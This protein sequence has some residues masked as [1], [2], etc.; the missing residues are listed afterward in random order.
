MFMPNNVTLLSI[1]TNGLKSHSHKLMTFSALINT[2]NPNIFLAQ[3]TNLVDV[4]SPTFNILKSKYKL[5]HSE[6]PHVGS[7]LLLGL[8]GCAKLSSMT[9]LHPG[10][11]QRAHIQ[12]GSFQL[13][14]Y[15]LHFPPNDCE[16]LKNIQSKIIS[17]I[18]K[19]PN[20]PI[21]LG[22]DFNFVEDPKLDSTNPHRI[23]TSA[24]KHFV[25]A[26]EH[27]HFT[28]TFRYLHPQV[29]AF[30]FQRGSSAQSRIDKFY[31]ARLPND[32]IVES[33][34]LYYPLSDHQPIFLSLSSNTQPNTN[35][36]ETYWKLNNELLSQQPFVNEVKTFW[37]CWQAQKPFFSTRG[38]WWD[39]GKEK[40][41]KIAIKHG[42]QLKTNKIT[43][44]QN[45]Q[46]I[47]DK[48]ISSVSPDPNTI[49]GIQQAF[50]DQLD[51]AAKLALNKCYI[52]RRLPF[53]APSVFAPLLEQSQQEARSPHNLQ[54]DQGNLLDS[55]EDIAQ[56]VLCFY[57][58][59]YEAE[60]IDQTHVK[61]FLQNLPVLTNEDRIYL[62]QPITLQELTAA[63]QK[64]SNCKAPGIDGLSSEFYK[65]FWN[66]LGPD[67]LEVFLESQSLK[68]LPTSTRTSVIT[69]IPKTGDT[70][71]LINWRPISVGCSDYKIIA[72]ALA[73]RLK[74][75]ISYLIHQDQTCSVPG[76]NIH[77]NVHRIRDCIFLAQALQLPLI[78][79]GLDQVKAFDLLHH[80][81][82][83]AVLKANGFG[84]NYRSYL[85][86]LYAKARYSIKLHRTILPPFTPGRGIRQ[87]CSLSTMLYILATEPLLVQIR[88]K[89]ER[90]AFL[91]TISQHA[92]PVSG[93]ADDTHLLL[94]NKEAIPKLKAITNKFT[95]ASNAKVND[96]KSWIFYFGSLAGETYNPYGYQLKTES[97][98]ILGVTLGVTLEAQM[99]MWNRL[100]TKVEKQTRIWSVTASALTYRQRAIL[101]NTMI[102]STLWYVITAA[103]PPSSF[104]AQVDRLCLN[105]LWTRRTHRVSKNLVYRPVD[106]GGLGLI[107]VQRQI[108]AYR[109]K[110]IFSLLNKQLHPISELAFRY[111]LCKI[112][113][114]SN[115][116][117]ILNLRHSPPKLCR[118]EPL[119]HRPTLKLWF[120]NPPPISPPETYHALLHH[121][122]YNN[123]HL[124][125]MRPQEGMHHHIIFVK[126]LFDARGFEKSTSAL[127]HTRNPSTRSRRSA[128]IAGIKT[129]IRQAGFSIT[130]ITPTNISLLIRTSPGSPLPFHLNPPTNKALPLKSIT[131]YLSRS[132]HPVVSADVKTLIP[133]WD[134]PKILWPFTVRSPLNTPR[135]LNTQWLVMVGA[136]PHIAQVS[137]FIPGIRSQCPMCAEPKPGVTHMFHSCRGLAP[138]FALVRQI[139][140]R[141]DPKL[142]LDSRSWWFGGSFKQLP[143]NKTRYI[144]FL[145]ALTK[146]AIYKTYLVWYDDPTKLLTPA[147]FVTAFRVRLKQSLTAQYYQLQ[148]RQLEQFIATWDPGGIVDLSS[149]P[150][151][152]IQI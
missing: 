41:K 89:M 21:I 28:D 70:T 80:A 2:H 83:F 125:N 103:H 14:L 55:Q 66:L 3:E 33:K 123:P 13:I 140:A 87:G 30:T 9:V 60:P 11:V 114:H 15:N 115:R 122:I 105:L 143:A 126:D 96:Q 5:H 144:N 142:P 129:A 74:T 135:E 90:Y 131:S 106:E 94:N 71:R 63:V 108:I 24:Y 124:G 78:L 16:K 52:P 32:R 88:R 110:Y 93:Y 29:K 19:D 119:F 82:L 56:H 130:A 1:N 46:E 69:L 39:A 86:L 25:Y 118:I 31:L 59:L 47:L 40:I 75:V 104:I 61:F 112:S 10:Y 76:R 149:P 17:S 50:K 12:L 73:T 91:H 145:F 102:L 67:L 77:Q 98:S 45:L 37:P 133:D 146:Q 64:A 43:S 107:S 120:Q 62:D 68:Q 7:G 35:D 81:Y 22:G 54:D 85:R 92:T 36:G 23:T 127:V 49:K 84:D 26:L 121:P 38:E 99:G 18:S 116:Q 132:P 79:M 139:L 141:I 147:M 27:F 42:K 34:I 44:L 134:T 95:K 4:D 113:I 58:K 111:S 109:H 150:Y 72:R 100:L 137:H 53:Y 148:P 136:I 97:V 20:L 101:I 48:E 65:E 8:A 128:H 151:L 57:K 6:G 117:R 152:K 51:Q 138:L